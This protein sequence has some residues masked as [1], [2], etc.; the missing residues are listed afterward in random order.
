MDSEHKAYLALWS[1]RS[2]VEFMIYG[3]Q[4]AMKLLCTYRMANTEISKLASDINL[5]R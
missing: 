5:L 4:N 2:E 3:K 1:S